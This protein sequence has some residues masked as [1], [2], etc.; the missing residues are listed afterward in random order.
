MSK[1]KTEE[2][3]TKWPKRENN[4]YIDREKKE[5]E[6]LTTDGLIDTCRRSFYLSISV[7]SGRSVYSSAGGWCADDLGRHSEVSSSTL[8]TT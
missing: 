6:R 2:E 5:L 1:T 7:P 4:S 3:I 8:N